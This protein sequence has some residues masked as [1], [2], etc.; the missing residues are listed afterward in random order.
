MPAFTVTRLSPNRFLVEGAYYVGGRGA[1]TP[2]ARIFA[3]RKK[4]DADVARWN[5]INARAEA[6][7]VET[8]AR[9]LELAREYLAARA[10]RPQEA[11]LELI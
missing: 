5:E 1:T 2:Y 6:D 10:A 3:T 8:R 7:N 11:Q 9:R 4:A